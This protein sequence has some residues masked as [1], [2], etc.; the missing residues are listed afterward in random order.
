MKLLPLATTM[1]CWLAN[2]QHKCH[3]KKCS[4]FENNAISH[5]TFV[6]QLTCWLGIP[7]MYI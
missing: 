1:W 6:G 3:M 2:G 4:E 5:M 7:Y